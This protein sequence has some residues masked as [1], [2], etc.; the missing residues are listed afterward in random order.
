MFLT[1]A[2]YLK[3]VKRKAKAQ[4]SQF[5]H[6]LTTRATCL[7]SH[8]TINHDKL[9]LICLLPI[10]LVTSSAGAQ[11]TNGS[12]WNS[13]FRVIVDERIEDC[14]ALRHR[15]PYIK[16]LSLECPPEPD[17]RTGYVIC[18]DRGNDSSTRRNADVTMVMIIIPASLPW[19]S[20]PAL[21]LVFQW[22]QSGSELCVRWFC[23]FGV[24][25]HKTAFS[26]VCVVPQNQKQPHKRFS[27][28]LMTFTLTTSVPGSSLSH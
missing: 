24:K 13:I 8:G 19:S 25:K 3:Q 2:K 6:I 23:R 27:F 1:K 9:Q 16:F 4:I 10:G 26:D 7:S 15:G 14:A 22:A 5:H 11:L 20:S 17:Q 18:S 21:W 12:I 28:L